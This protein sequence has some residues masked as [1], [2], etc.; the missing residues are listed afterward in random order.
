[1][2]SVLFA[3]VLCS[4]IA[5]SFATYGVDVSQETLP[6]AWSCLKQ[7]GYSFGIVRAYLSIG[8]VD[9]VGPHTI[10]NAW[11]GGMSHVDVYMFP[12]PQ[13]GKSAAT[14]VQEAVQNL[15][16][17][18]CQYGM[19][20]FDI[21]GSQY[22]NDVASNRAWLTEAVNQALSMGQT[23]GIYTSQ[24]QWSSIMGSWTGAS[25]FP[26]WYAHYDNNPSFSDFSPFGG[27]NQPAIKQYVATPSCAALA[28]TR[29][30]TLERS[31][32]S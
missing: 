26:L 9:S 12:C 8:Q 15:R 7:N 16:N 25:R 20:W 17:Y 30:S 3:L 18:N 21:E 2:K 19:F 29:T 23:V 24:Y 6:S 31:R 32:G 13:C 1:M 28:S 4:L 5:A 27:W 14:Q 10:Y 22:W 11:A